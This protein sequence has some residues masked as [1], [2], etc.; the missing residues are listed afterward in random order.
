MLNFRYMLLIAGELKDQTV[1]VLVG[2]LVELNVGL[3]LRSGLLR[4]V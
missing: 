4:T 2:W 3:E 1:K